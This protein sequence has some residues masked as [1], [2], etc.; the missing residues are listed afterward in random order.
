MTLPPT[1]AFP[2]L[3]LSSGA[4]ADPHHSPDPSARRPGGASPSVVA[5][6]PAVR[7]PSACFI[8]PVSVARSTS[9]VAPSS[10]RA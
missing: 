2:R 6:N 5:Y 10:S 4:D 1:G 9:T 7:A 3:P 8:A